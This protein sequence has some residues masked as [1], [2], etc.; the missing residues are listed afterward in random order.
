M[1]LKKVFL[2]LFSVLFYQIQAQER[3]LDFDV[4][5]QIE[6]SG[7]IQVVENITIKAEGNEF[8]HGLLRVLPL[9]REDKNGNQI[10][11]EYSISSIKKD[12]KEEQYFTERS[13]YDWKIYIGSKNVVLEQGVYQY[14]ISYSVPFQIGYFD[15]YDELYWNVTGN[16]W[17]FPIDNATCQISLPSENNRFQNLH[18]Y[19]GTAGST[20]SNCTSSLNSKNTI[21]TFSASNLRSNEGLTVAAS[22]PKGVVD[23]PTL[24]Q[25]LESYYKLVKE[26]LWSVLFV[27]GMLIFFFL[28][29][30]K[31]GK[32]P[33]K[34]TIIPEFVPP[35]NWSPAI[36]GYV[37]HKKIKEKTY[38]ASLINTAVKGAIRICPVL[39]DGVLTN[40]DNYEIEVLNKDLKTLS[41]EESEIIRS[42]SKK[43]I[44]VKDS[45]HRIFGKAYSNWSQDVTRQIDLDN[46]Y[47]K[48]NNLKW[49][50]FLVFLS[51][52][53][54][55]EMLS[56]TEGYINY[57]FYC[58]LIIVIYGLTFL[59]SKK[60]F[61]QVWIVLKIFVSFFVLLPG[62]FI[63]LITMSFLNDMQI[64]TIFF[65]FLM[66]I[67]YAWSIGR[68][69][70]KGSE[71][72]SKL[73]G[74]RLYLETA[75]KDRMNMLNPPELTP[76]LFEKLFP[77][78][79]ALN[80]EIVWGK[81]FEE[82]LEQAKYNPEWYQGDDSFYVR[83]TM[84]LSGLSN[85]ISSAAVNPNPT[86]SSSSSSS[87]SSSG[88][89]SGS[90][91]SWSSGS[92]GGG[93]SG[94]GGGGGGGGGW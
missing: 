92:S 81:Q 61:D 66:Y 22:F 67:F 12:G 33:A 71:A 50:G 54:F 64:V 4:K 41:R 53:L 7:T 45:N 8:R 38:M 9:T 76:Q 88:G 35:F 70:E 57:I 94:G 59:F 86:R 1:S 48:N 14:E 36:V 37:Y 56:K 42:F 80:V 26:Y 3:I 93:S 55:Y 30:K 20:R 60:T 46:L 16:R 79:I 75:E 6:K 51:A 39:E 19:T 74:F 2:V 17:Y 89:S 10:D 40:A 24:L 68:N 27:L 69:T 47:E 25:K 73:K 90:S 85:S 83:P 78:A 72:I 63:F 23:S 18:C 52:G 77:Y 21:V 82:I 65:V 13:K 84:F 31:H 34:K 28:S 49:V 29:W 87:S 5:V 62:V 44:K 32:E 43:K 15:D 91:G 11:V 58:G